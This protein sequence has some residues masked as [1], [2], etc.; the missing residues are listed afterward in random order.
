M[1]NKTQK[2]LIDCDP[3]G[4][5]VFALLWLLINHEFAHLPIEV[6]GITTV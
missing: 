2:I 5:D 6:I 4:D 3:G 1:S